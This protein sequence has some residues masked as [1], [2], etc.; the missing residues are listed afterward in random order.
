MPF[1]ISRFKST[2]DKYGGPARPSLF[3]VIIF[4]GEETNSQIEPLREFSFFCKSVNFP[5][6]SI[7]NQTFT[8]VGQRP[9]LFPSTMSN[10]P[11]NAIFMVDSD[12]QILS[13]FHNWIQRVLNYS[14][15]GG[16]FGAIDV[17]DDPRFSG[18]LPYEVG[19]KDEYSCRMI[20]R[21]YSTESVSDKYY[22]VVLDNVYPYAV[23]ELDLAWETNDSFLTLPVAFS[24][25]KIYYSNDR[26][27]SPS[28]RLGGGL[29][30]T[31]GDLAG[32][33]DVTK[34]VINQGK[35]RSIQDAVNRLSRIRNS[36]DNLSGFFERASKN[37]SGG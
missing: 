16:P 11:I 27:G 20:I 1:N 24:Y 13:F 34:Q 28:R 18:Q 29:L 35:P 37:G 36:Y 25:D 15:K 6:V 3:E 12:H 23:G 7:E 33:V 9:L 17:G 5:G 2:F 32:L 26:T 4:K 14:T 22:E 30:E 19:Y 10:D 21:H 31:L 8:A